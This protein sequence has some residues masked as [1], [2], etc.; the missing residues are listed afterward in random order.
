MYG[1]GDGNVDDIVKPMKKQKKA[2]EINK[3]TSKSVFIDDQAVRDSDE[4]GDDSSDEDE[5][6][7]DANEYVEDGFVVRDYAKDGDDGIEDDDSAN[8]SIGESKPVKRTLTRLKKGGGQSMLD[9]EDIDLIAENAGVD[10]GDGRGMDEDD[11]GNVIAPERVKVIRKKPKVFGDEDGAVSGG[12]EESDGEDEEGDVEYAFMAG[13]RGEVREERG[14]SE[15]RGRE[16]YAPLRGHYRGSGGGGGSGPSRDAMDEAVDIFGDGYDE[17]ND[18]VD[19][20]EDDDMFADETTEHVTK[21]DKDILA[22]RAQYEHSE[23][24]ESFCADS[25][26]VIRALDYPERLIQVAQSLT[27]GKLSIRVPSTENERGEEAYWIKNRLVADKVLEGL[28]YAEEEAITKSIE[29]V[30]KFYHVS[31]I[32]YIYIYIS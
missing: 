9:Q 8:G 12:E 23:L 22:V 18:D 2:K 21:A 32:L 1:V 7:G 11:D 5:S 26:D 6:V 20:E 19:D 15:G 16:R 27:K 25:D 4:E 24:V 30:L 14:S 10:R 13:E 31:K 17:Y 3:S 29:H 28:E